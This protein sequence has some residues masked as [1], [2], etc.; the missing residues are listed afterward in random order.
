[1]RLIGLTGGIACGKSTVS[2]EILRKGFPVIDG[3]LL[4]RELTGPDGKAVGEIRSVFGERF[5]NPDGSMNRRAMGRLVFSDPLAREK[6]DRLMAPYLEALTSER[7]EDVRQSGAS[8]C[9]LDMPLLFE[10]GYDRL[11]DTIWCVWLPDDVQLERL[12]SRD[13]LSREEALS[14]IRSVLASDEK[15]RLSSAVIDNSGPVGDTLSQVSLLLD[16]ELARAAA[17]RRRRRTGVDSSSPSQ[18]GRLSPAENPEPFP[19]A[20]E[21]PDSARRRPSDRK[22]SPRLPR[23][24]VVLLVALSASLAVALTSHLL[25][26]AY[27]TRRVRFH[28]EEQQAID[29]QYPLEYRDLIL[30]QSREFNLSPALIASVIRNESS[31]RPSAESSVGARGLMQLMPDTASWIAHKLRMDDYSLEK[32]YDP[33][34]NVRLGSWYLNYLSSLFAGDPLCVICAYHAGQG[35]IKGWLSNPLYS[36]NG[37]TLLLDRLPDGP[38]KTYAGRVTRDYGIYLQKYFSP[39]SSAS[40]VLSADLS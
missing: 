5:L 13:G 37:K 11:C 9:V 12:M 31:F 19:T 27:L 28:Q 34:V 39:V 7:I 24:T 17:P 8:L 18:A 15:A 33:E 22:V 26:R 32:L 30:K 20:V 4:A 6:L 23:W 25:M 40:A 38:T 3:D 21:R 10:K 1:M 35:E 36:S 14:R 16:K 2:R 29:R